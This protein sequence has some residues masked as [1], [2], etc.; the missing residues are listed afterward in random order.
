MSQVLKLILIALFMA[1]GTVL[2]AV[3]PSFP[4]KPDLLLSMMF[5]AIFLLS[6]RKNF[7]VIGLVA[8]LLSGLTTTIP[9][10]F[11]PNVIDKL[12]TA[13]VIFGI[14]SLIRNVIPK[15]VNALVL[16]ALGTVLSGTV[17]LTSLALIISLPP[18]TSFLGLFL[19]IVLP[20]AAINTVLMAVVFPIAQQIMKNSISNRNTVKKV[21]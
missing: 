7:L 15:Y 16:T 20:T 3:V 12:I 19:A 6:D 21:G 13:S 8:G 18:G 2:H 5:L 10:G 14:F 9:G 11:L 1:I 17:F 4:M